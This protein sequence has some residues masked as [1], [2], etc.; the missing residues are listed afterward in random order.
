M[1]IFCNYPNPLNFLMMFAKQYNS[2]YIE[3]QQF[4]IS[5]FFISFSE[6]SNHF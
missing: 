2:S 4:L 5:T 3:I 6:L 1:Q